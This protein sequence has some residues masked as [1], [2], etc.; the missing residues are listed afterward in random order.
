M[1]NRDFMD[2]HK[3]RFIDRSLLF[4]D[5]DELFAIF[6]ASAKETVLTSHGGLTYGGFI[7]G[8]GAKQHTVNDCFTAL[9]SYAKTN[10]FTKI[11]GS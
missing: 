2:Y 11:I 3:D 10:G 7:L 8:A 5:D 6:P 4:Y 9:L 1:F